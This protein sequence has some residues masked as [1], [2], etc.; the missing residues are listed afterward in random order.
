MQK[1]KDLTDEFI[2]P[3]IYFPAVAAKITSRNGR[4]NEPTSKSLFV[5]SLNSTLGKTQQVSQKNTINQK[6][7][8][9]LQKNMADVMTGAAVYKD[10]EA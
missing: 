8:T 5:A 10:D 6:K 9:L 7:N 4:R 3:Q 2:D 1:E